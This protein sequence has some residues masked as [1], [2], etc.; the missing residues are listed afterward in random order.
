MR[1]RSRQVLLAL[2]AIA[3]LGIVA[4]RSRRAFHSGNFSGHR[5]IHAVREA[6]IWMLLAAVVLI[7][8]CYALRARRWQRFCCYLG[9]SNFWGIYNGTIMGFATIFLLG[10]AG[11]PVRPLLLARKGKYPAASQFGIYILERIFD[12]ASSA[13]IAILALLVFARQLG[14]AGA[15]PDSVLKARASG[16]VLLGVIAG[17][18]IFLVYYRLYGAEAFGRL[19]GRWHVREGWRRRVA[20]QFLAF[21][22]GLHA[23]RT[24]GDLAW[25]ILYSGVHWALVAGV[26]LIIARSFGDDFSDF[27]YPSAM[28]LLAVTMLGSV[29]QLPGV[30]GGAQVAS[31]I[32]FTTI[33][34]VDPEPAAAA[35]VVLWLVTFAASLLIGVPM[36]LREGWSIGA[37]RK[38]ARAEAAAVEAGDMAGLDNTA[39]QSSDEKNAAG[40]ALR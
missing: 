37:L 32:A 4:Y 25:A 5:L 15:D 34:G 16:G 12:F 9:P 40:D 20:V 13:M 39:G 36:L 33:F 14:D 6:N 1:A 24:W 11:E 2:L 23:I 38:L 7:Y 31:F 26:Y 18:A 30:G 17:A 21:R 35:A 3:A 22:E 27:N 8:V 19:L 28:L 29:L 10:R